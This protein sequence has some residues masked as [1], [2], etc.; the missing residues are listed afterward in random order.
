MDPGPVPI[1]WIIKFISNKKGK[2][3]NC[4]PSAVA[5]RWG[6]AYQPTNNSGRCGAG[7]NRYRR[8]DLRGVRMGILFHHFGSI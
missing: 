5:E 4:R 8:L 3:K 1:V 7:E 2:Y 6:H